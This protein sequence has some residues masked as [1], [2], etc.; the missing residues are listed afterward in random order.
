MYYLKYGVMQHVH[1]KAS[2]EMC[3]SDN[4]LKL[5]GTINTYLQKLKHFEF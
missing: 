5:F 2:K 1:I 4:I 3:Q